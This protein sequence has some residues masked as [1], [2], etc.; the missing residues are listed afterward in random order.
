MGS[1]LVNPKSNKLVGIAGLHHGLPGWWAGCPMFWAAACD[2][3][4]TSPTSWLI[5]MYA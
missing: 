2:L 1:I 4:E 5:V 3:T